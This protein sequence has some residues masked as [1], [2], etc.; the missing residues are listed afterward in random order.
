MLYNHNYEVRPVKTPQ[1]SYGN[2]CAYLL[3]KNIHRK[4]KHNLNIRNKP[5]EI[6]YNVTDIFKKYAMQ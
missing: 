3:T 6:D 5:Y 1:Q 4:F 2:P